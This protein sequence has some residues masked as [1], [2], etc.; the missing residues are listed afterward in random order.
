MN[1]LKITQINVNERARAILELP[2]IYFISFSVLSTM[3]LMVGLKFSVKFS[4]MSSWIFFLLFVAGIPLWHRLKDIF[5][6]GNKS[7]GDRLFVILVLL[8][9]LAGALLATS[10]NRPDI[11]DSIYVP[12]SVFYMENPDSELNMLMNWVA[13]LPK[14]TSTGIFQYYEITQ[15]ALAFK[16]NIHFLDLYHIVFPA[17]V[18]FLMCISM[19]LV[20]SLF[21]QRR[22]PPLLSVFFLLLIILSLGETHRA[23][24]NLSIARGFHAKYMFMSVGVPAWVYFSLQFL[25]LRRRTTWII[26]TALGISMAGASTTAMVFLPFLSALVAA[27]YVFN[28]GE[29]FFLKDTLY[30]V[31]GYFSCLLP[32]VLLALNFRSYAKNNLGAGSFINSGFPA[33]FQDQLRLLINP[34]YPLTPFLFIF[35]L[36]ILLFFSAY[37][38]FFLCWIAL[39]FIIFLNPVVSGF[40]I[41]NFTSENIYWRLFYL[42]PFPIIIAIAYLS[43][44][45][46]SVASRAVS[47]LATGI[48][49]Y[50]A[51]WGPTSVI[52]TEN[53]AILAFPG[54]KIHEPELSMV[55]EIIAAFPRGSMLAPLEISSNI[56]L[57]S[58]KYPQF[59]MRE[60]HLGFFLLN[61]GQHADFA[62][63][64][65]L[66][67][68]LYQDDP[69]QD[70]KEGKEALAKLISSMESPEL[71]V[72]YDNSSNKKGIENTLLHHGYVRAMKINHNYVVFRRMGSSAT[73]VSFPI[74]G[75]DGV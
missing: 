37:R 10:I 25:T 38:R 44:L 2:L 46:N 49:F 47:L 63:R 48:A 22:W 13:G 3:S 42:L 23:F 30:L 68:Y 72:T 40:I 51:F 36:A 54:Y 24:G 18:G 5:K 65:K 64:S 41:N 8:V 70:E 33:S 39:G 58:S 69:N 73:T 66:F 7:S 56:V 14:T 34:D 26:L 35:S 21:D 62:N 20:V 74:Y 75:T 61:N 43:L 4:T 53:N 52:R 31:G 67:R 11:D 12:K 57:L 1:N 6:S 16:L 15:A 71:V 29:G 59:H 45:K 9:S 60:D 19:F 32:V 27:S 50:S 55:K 17:I 28:E